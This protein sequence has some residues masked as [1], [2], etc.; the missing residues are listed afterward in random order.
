V[1]K[2]AASCTCDIYNCSSTATR[3]SHVT[4]YNR[5][6]IEIFL[7]LVMV[8]VMLV[9]ALIP[10]S[11]KW[12]FYVFGALALFY[13]AYPLLFDGLR[14]RLGSNKGTVLASS[15]IRTPQPES[16]AMSQ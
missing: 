15:L 7:I 10:T 11:Y 14:S 9:S 12:G 13:V 6:F 1:D 4:V 16:H 8:E 5:P 3:P 2:L